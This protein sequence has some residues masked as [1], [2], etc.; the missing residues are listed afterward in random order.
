MKQVPLI[1]KII[2]LLL[3]FSTEVKD[4]G[5]LKLADINIISEDV[6]VPILSIVYDTEL[7]N[8]NEEKAN[9]PGID[10]ATDKHFTFAGA[11]KKIAFQ[12][13][14][15][16]NITKI[17][18]TL[19]Q[20]VKK[21]FY[22]SFDEIYIYN[23]IEKQAS[24]QQESI[25]EVNTII[26]GKF[27]FDLTKHVIDR[28][29]L[30]KKIAKLQPIAKIEKIHKLLEDQ[31]V[32]RKKSLLSLE[33]WESEGKIG[34]GFSN[35]I[36]GIDVTTYNTLIKKG[37]SDDA[38]DVLHLLLG[39]YN[40]A[41]AN[42]YENGT[43]DKFKDLAFNTYIKA[44]FEQAVNSFLIIK[45]QIATDLDIDSFTSSISKA[46][47]NTIEDIDESDFPLVN[48]PFK[49]PAIKLIKD[50]IS[51][52][53]SASNIDNVLTPIMQAKIKNIFFHS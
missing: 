20:Y 51:K 28:T 30:E 9:Y 13:T 3:Q 44:G 37:I 43:H 8:L 32:Y 22:D 16:N 40:T 34:Y 1:E 2:D 52:L 24:Y 4:K 7:K 11:K 5:K 6:L 26:D 39:K 12:I 29:D 48:Q 36:N 45:D 47:S 50:I 18:K 42:N 23:L 49:H 35:L 33:I 38:K 53:F 21:Q 14:S 31:F 46:F 10:L 17:K 27:E 25:N 41:F 15:T 19:N